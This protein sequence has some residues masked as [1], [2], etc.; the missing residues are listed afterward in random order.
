MKQR[1]RRILIIVIPLLLALLYG[2]TYLP[3]KVI[4]IN[5]AAVAKINIFNGN[6]G[7]QIEITD[8]ADIQQIINNLN[9][10]VFQK[11]KI[12]LGY[13]GYS[14]RT[15]I[16]DH[17]GKAIEEMIINSEHKIRYKGFF[18]ETKGKSIN[19]DYIDRFFNN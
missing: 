10:V 14:F 5:P 3:Q 2:T 8:E 12:S 13:M 16:Y 19:Y 6:T 7:Q 4:S 17:Q 1:R 18:Y 15:T 9:E 11:G